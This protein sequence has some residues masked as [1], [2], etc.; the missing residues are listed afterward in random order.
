MNYVWVLRMQREGLQA[1]R[2]LAMGTRL[3]TSSYM[4]GDG[5]CTIVA[6]FF[7]F[8]KRKGKTRLL[9]TYLIRMTKAR[10]VHDNTLRACMHTACFWVLD[11]EMT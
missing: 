11:K 1:P 3:C 7:S 9:V 8:L 6:T 2:S 4:V 10:L 5:K